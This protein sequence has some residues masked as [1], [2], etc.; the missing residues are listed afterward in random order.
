M[1]VL[2]EN[3][4][5]RSMRKSIVV[6]AAC[7]LF[8]AAS[9]SLPV[10]AEDG[11]LAI[12]ATGGT[13][14]LGPEISYRFNDH[15]GIRVNG[16]F[17]DYDDT[18][19]LDDIEYDA[20]LKLNSFGAM[21][22]W[23][24]LGGGFRISAGGRVNDNK[25]D[26]AGTPSAPVEIGNVTY[27]PAQVGTLTGTVTTDSFAPALTLGY[28]GKLAKGFTFGFELGVMLQGSPK[29]DNL[30][31]TGGTLASNP[32]FLTQLAVEENNA[33]EDAKDFKLWPIVQ[34]S[35]AYRF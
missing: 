6:A 27:T 1:F 21:L 26:L 3:L 9:V 22:D 23:Y 35:L 17:Y 10:H 4:E 11:S 30:T 33:E 15:V 32:A 29:I 34:L 24:P 7:G 12:G 19:D 5:E 20:T 18:D 31:A 8:T 2:S 28:G 16:G 14:G 25:I 13:L